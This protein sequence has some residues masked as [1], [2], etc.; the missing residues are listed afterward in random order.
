MGPRFFPWDPLL[1]LNAPPLYI[2]DL[3]S[4]LSSTMARLNLTL[5]LCAL[6]LSV[7]TAKRELDT[8]R[9][10]CCVTWWGPTGS[11]FRSR[12]SRGVTWGAKGTRF[13]KGLTGTRV[14]KGPTG[15]SSRKWPQVPAVERVHG[16]PQERVP[17]RKGHTG[18]RCRKGPTGTRCRKGSSRPSVDPL[19][20]QNCFSWAGFQTPS[21]QLKWRPPVRES[22]TNNSYPTQNTP[23]A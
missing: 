3:L 8:S 20:L 15:T 10:S 5:L 14:R 1:S 7:V 13:R 19:Q 18:T 9:E 21:T 22:D 16:Y 6:L 4:A 11:R 12:E 23:C 2:A 17:P